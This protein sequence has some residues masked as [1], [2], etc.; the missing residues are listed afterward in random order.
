MPYHVIHPF[1]KYT[2]QQI[3]VSLSLHLP[4]F[5]GCNC[6]HDLV[7][8]M[9]VTP[10][11]NSDHTGSQSPFLPTLP[12]LPTLALSNLQSSF[13]TY[14][15]ACSGL[16]VYGNSLLPF[17]LLEESRFTMLLVS[18]IQRSDSNTYTHIYIYTHTHTYIL[19]QIIFSYSLLQN[20]EYSSLCYTVGPCWLSILYICVYMLISNS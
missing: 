9:L 4:Q 1:E 13:S 3:C 18:G 2:I 15:F 16:R 7:L 10:K 6:H 20:I 5:Y 12:H 19:F 14:K 8:K 11:I 17:F